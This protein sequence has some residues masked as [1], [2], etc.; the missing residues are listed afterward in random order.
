MVENLSPDFRAFIDA[1]YENH[2]TPE[3]ILGYIYAVLYAPTYRARWAEFLRIDFPRVP[4]P[5]LAD[6]FEILSGLGWALVQAHL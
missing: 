3:E 2:Y 4:F 1:R 5:D 6:D